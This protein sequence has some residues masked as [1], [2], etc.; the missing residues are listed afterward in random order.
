MYGNANDGSLPSP[1]YPRDNNSGHV[2]PKR[3]NVNTI[4]TDINDRY[5]NTYS[6]KEVF[7]QESHNRDSNLWYMCQTDRKVK[8][9]KFR[10]EIEEV[11]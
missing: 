11:E 8:R 5:E 6:P 9:I 7:Y 4:G 1:F 3:L 2:H 10:I